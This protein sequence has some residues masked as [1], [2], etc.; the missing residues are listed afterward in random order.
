[1]REGEKAP[2][3]IR[4]RGD[5]YQ[6]GL[7]HA[8]QVTHLLPA[9]EAAIEA[10]YVQ[11][12]SDRPDAAFEATVR[13]TVALLQEADP[14]T[15]A[16]IRGLADGLRLEYE[17][18]LH[19]NLVTFLRDILT[20]RNALNREQQSDTETEGCSTWAAANGATAGG[21][22]VLAK[23]RDFSMEHLPVQCVVRAEPANG[24]RYTYI[25]SAG[26]PG[27]F[28]A[29]FNEAGLALVD[30]HVSSTDVGPGLPTYAL[31]MH[32]LEEQHTVSGALEYLASSPRLGRNNLL[33]ADAS[34]S[35]ALFEI[36]HRH[37]A[38]QRGGDV[39]VNTN[40][41]TSEAMRPFHVDTEFTTL[42]GNSSARHKLLSER[43]AEGYGKIDVAFA[44][45]LMATHDGP[46]ASICRHPTPEESTSTISATIFL[47]SQ[48]QMYFCH[49]QPCSSP[50][51]VFDYT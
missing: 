49:G 1:M 40:H 51:T 44:Q 6:M 38:I 11:L 9:I 4:V 37:F 35:L 18:L 7:D 48:R 22:P 3:V 27:V 23:N 50:Y 29:G 26:S 28:V 19:Y 15:L 16:F 8:R 13:E 47:P 33:L 46:M 25:T 42:R 5:H 14:S 32:L 41:F 21:Y 43:L 36:G 31:S 12:A 39:L 30:T 34:G 24:H 20:T 2:Q 17:R 10:R 45:G